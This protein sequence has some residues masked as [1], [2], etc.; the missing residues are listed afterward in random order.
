M[1]FPFI[2]KFDSFNRLSRGPGFPGVGS[3]LRWVCAVVVGIAW[4]ARAGEPP[5]HAR[6]DALL[7]EAHPAG[8]A[9]LADD[10]DF[11]R[12]T[13]L[14]LHGVIPTV[15]QARAFLADTAPDKRAKLAETLLADPQF[16]KWMAVRFDVMLMERR[17]E[18]Q[19]K[20]G[21]WREWLEQS[22]VA[23]KPWDTLVRELIA[24]DGADEKTRHVARWLLEREVDPNAL[25]RDAAR[26]FLGRDISCSQCHDHPRIDDY[27][28]R[29]YA[30]LQ[31]FF[32]RS[33]LFRPDTKK[34]GI[35]G[36]QAAGDTTYLSVF[37]KVGGGTK[38]RLP[39]EGEL[40]EPAPGEWSVPPDA[41]DKTLRPVPKFSRRALLATALGDGHHPAFRRNIANRLWAIVFGRGLVEPLD[42]HHSANPPAIPP[43]LDLLGDQIAA[44]KF[45]TRAFVRE[46]VLT[47]AFQRALDLPGPSADVAAVAAKLAELEK[48]SAV[49]ASAAHAAEERF[50]AEQKATAEAQRVAAP[51]L[52]E[53]LKLDADAAAARKPLDAALAEQKK[54]DD[55]LA[56]K[57]AE[58]KALADA[59]AKVAEAAAA[60]G[61]SPELVAAGKTFQAKSGAMT[62]ALAAAEKD[63]AAKKADADAK[64]KV[65][66]T[67]R[68]AAIAARTKSDA[69][70]SRIAVRQAALDAAGARKESDRVRAKHA[71]QLVA[72]AKAA[73]AWSEAAGA[74]RAAR[75]AA[76]K[77]AD[78]IQET[79]R[80]ADQMA[81]EIAN[82]PAKIA[83]LETMSA[84]A[85]A[86]A[87]KA[88]EAA[89]AR[90]PA[91][92]VLAEAVAKTAEAAAT[93][94]N[95]AEVKK[96][97][98]A[99]KSRADAAT[100]EAA[101]ASKTAADAQTRADAIA[102]QIADAGAALAEAKAGIASVQAQVPALEAAAKAARAKAN[103]TANAEAAAREAVSSAWGR[104]FAAMELLPLA[105]EQ[106]CWSLMQ[107]TGQLD[108]LRTSAA[109]EWDSK[110]KLSDA[111][112]ANPARQA[113]RAAGIDKLFRD[114]LRAQEA[115]FVRFFGGAA[116]Q[117]QTDFFATP[118]QALFFE[119]GGVIRQW[120]ASLAT[121]A[122]ALP[123]P[124]AMAEEIYLA[125]LTRLPDA[126][127]V[128]ELGAML[129]AR[130]PER[131][132]D[133]LGDFAWA[134][135]ASLEF[136]FVH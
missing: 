75:Q 27:L 21:P 86:E 130:P 7:A 118:E 113:E 61:E 77:A 126:T 81:A 135:L 8:Q 96:A 55:V 98:A 57:R 26:L 44:M 45:D 114:R 13:Y 87:V 9:P 46:L 35:I 36:E 134:L 67:A 105:P 131:K 38:P 92:A 85:S 18:A 68:Q 104:A 115:T 64:A 136:R 110:N 40:A 66:E 111:D 10:A 94:P 72:E 16:A 33:Y 62:A 123:D 70:T 108:P 1:P 50:I 49:L 65:F 83:A 12:R 22:F 88:K 90:L 31:A 101:A 93:L 117:P 24:A 121:R 128:A 79:K 6:I 120:A 71:A 47:Q 69:A 60:A 95:D 23:N 3:T 37:T 132:A 80:K 133:A 20:E 73:I 124:K 29:D 58:H 109:A 63:A 78:A 116:G 43:L 51:V 53:Q 48:N 89:N 84:A 119:N 41:R 100:A 34:P 11:L 4:A 125:T 103:E 97:A 14:S 42:L 122:A 106:L 74:S 17:G 19:T 15:A 129:V 76:V 99:V 107:A 127:E 32:S 28:Q 56:A 25:A 5:L 2:L 112:K 82:A 54:A 91:V 30:G 59:A 39:A 102:K 52:A